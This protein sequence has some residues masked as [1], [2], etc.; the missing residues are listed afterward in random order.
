MYLTDVTYEHVLIMSFIKR[1][2]WH[3]IKI[4]LMTLQI[5]R[6]IYVAIWRCNDIVF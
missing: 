4:V 1:R 5:W 3:V 2:D 6:T